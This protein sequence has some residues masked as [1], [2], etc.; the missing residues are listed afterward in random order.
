MKQNL[1]LSRTLFVAC[2]F[3]FPLVVPMWGVAAEP[4]EGT[5]ALQTKNLKEIATESVQD[6]LKACM[7]RIPADASAGQLLLAQQNCQQV[8]VERA[9]TALTF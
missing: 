7:A 9:G 4:V 1:C 5:L 2:L 3:L 8:A 6:T